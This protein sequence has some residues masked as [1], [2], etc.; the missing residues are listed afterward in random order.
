MPCRHRA[1]TDDTREIALEVTLFDDE[2]DSIDVQ[3]QWSKTSVFPLLSDPN[4]Q[5]LQAVRVDVPGRVQARASSLPPLAAD[6]VFAPELVGRSP[7][8]P[9]GHRWVGKTLELM[10]PYKTE[11]CGKKPGNLCKHC[12]RKRVEAIFTP[13]KIHVEK[14]RLSA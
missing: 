6:E 5:T 7:S 4:P 9:L 10:E 1:S 8:T 12:P 13:L 3:I 2:S 11:C 14:I